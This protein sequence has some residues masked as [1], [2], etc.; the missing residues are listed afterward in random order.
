MMCLGKNLF[1]FVF[2]G[3]IVIPDYEDLRFSTILAILL[4]LLIL[5]IILFLVVLSNI[6]L[7]SLSS[8][9]LTSCLYVNNWFSLG[10]FSPGADPE[11]RLW[12]PV[13]GKWTQEAEKEREG[14]TP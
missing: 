12:V 4:Y 7:F 5:F 13:L 6:S 1:F 8:R 10:G 9:F 3:I 14:K 11:T 2:L